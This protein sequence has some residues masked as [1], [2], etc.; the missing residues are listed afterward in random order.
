MSS[1][2]LDRVCGYKRGDLNFKEIANKTLY[3]LKK[4]KMRRGPERMAARD[5]LTKLF[6]LLKK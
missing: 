5:I 2:I 3:D 4:S 1:M 6:I